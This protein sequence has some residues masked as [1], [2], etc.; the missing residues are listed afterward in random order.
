MRSESAADLRKL[1]YPE[2]YFVGMAPA[3][4]RLALLSR[5]LSAKSGGAYLELGFGSGLSLNVHAAANGGVFWGNDFVPAHVDGAAAIAA[6][7]GAS[8]RLLPDSFAELLHRDDLPMFDMIVAHGI[9]TWVPDEDRVAIVELLRRK[10]APGGVFYVSYNN[11][12]GWSSVVYLRQL[13]KVFLA[14]AGPD[15]QITDTIA[16]ARS[17]QSAGA[18]YF[19]ENP[20]AS[21]ELAGMSAR[22]LVYLQQEYFLDDWKLMSVAE[23]QDALRPAE[24][25]FGAQFPLIVH[26]DELVLGP[27][28][29][30]ILSACASPI[31]RETVREAFQGM[32]FRQDIFVRQP[33]RLT[34]EQRRAAFRQQEFLLTTPSRSVMLKGGSPWGELDLAAKGCVPV[35]S[36][37]GELGPGPISVEQLEEA[38]PSIPIDDLITRVV[39][40]AAVR[41]LRPTISD[42]EQA[43]VRARC[44]KFN[45]HML[46]LPN[47]GNVILASP[48]L[49]AGVD[50]S[51]TERALLM[52]H[53]A[54][55]HSVESCAALLEASC[56]D[57]LH[58]R[59]PYRVA[60]AL[61]ADQLPILRAMGLAS[62]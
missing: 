55:D 40:L 59:S 8:A 19:R 41:V 12:A 47:D 62:D 31:L 23:M 38:L 56:G 11:T 5:G 44:E 32:G 51:R 24:L 6:I 57:E 39:L 9:W 43:T 13:M 46:S 20:T 16:F 27:M 53:L 48:V 49:G 7:S 33:D 29:A 15:T 37:L 3:E 50:V 34:Q 45:A 21:V 26:D 36:A 10:L 58:G 18:A 52:S 35:L 28:G 17:L 22:N 1:I 4:I 42:A 61:H 30:E 14:E 60:A 25:E 2:T 54:G